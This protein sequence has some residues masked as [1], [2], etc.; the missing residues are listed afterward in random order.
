MFI[1]Y[2]IFIINLIKKK[3]ICIYTYF[4]TIKYI[5]FFVN[6]SIFEKVL[7]SS[8]LNIKYYCTN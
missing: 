8:N 2:N 7:L 1:N 6:G 4:I 3:K 5:F